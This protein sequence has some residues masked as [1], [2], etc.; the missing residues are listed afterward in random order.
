MLRITDA[1]SG[2]LVDAARPRRGLTRVEA[3]TSGFDL[4]NLRVLLVADTLVRALELGGT[5]VWARLS[6]ERERAELRAGAAALG[7]RPFEEGPE[8]G[9]GLGEARV[10]HVAAKAD[11]GGMTG[12]GGVTGGDGSG[13]GGVPGASSG[14][15]APDGIPCAGRDD[16]EQGGAL[17]AGQGSPAAAGIPCAGEDDSEHGEAPRAGQDGHPAAGTPGAGQDGPAA[18]GIRLAVAPVVEHAAPDLAQEA[19]PAVLRLAL[20]ARPWSAPCRLDPAA[21]HDA[22]DTLVRWRRAVAGWACRPSRPIPDEVRA[23]VRAAWEDDLDVPGVLRVLRDVETDQELP[24][25]AR[26]ETYAHADRILGLDLARD[27]GGPA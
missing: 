5:P 21:L 1:R 11:G 2:E 7:I 9:A 6:G 16:S 23:R 27:L 12:G 13:P 17:G 15:P 4:T 3:H 18:G 8:A 10:I 14:G 20:L 22:R 19:D 26:F 24:D 25:G